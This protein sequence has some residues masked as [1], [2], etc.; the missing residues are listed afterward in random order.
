MQRQLQSGQRGAGAL[1]ESVFAHV[2]VTYITTFLPEPPVMINLSSDAKATRVEKPSWA[3]SCVAL[4]MNVQIMTEL[5]HSTE[6]IWWLSGE[7]VTSR[8]SLLWPS[9]SFFF[10]CAEFSKT[11]CIIPGQCEEVGCIS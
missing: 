5:S 1:N 10:A 6:M 7:N 3:L 4:A 11:E 8:I 2:S 9:K